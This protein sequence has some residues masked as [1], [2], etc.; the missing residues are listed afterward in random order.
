MEEVT[1]RKG[2]N[3]NAIR[4]IDFVTG[5]LGDAKVFPDKF[6]DLKGS[7]L[8]VTTNPIAVFFS[9]NFTFHDGNA[10]HDGLDV[11]IMD[12]IAKVMNFKLK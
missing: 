12:F 1:L 11:T 4:I 3:N 8:Q 9:N 7:V 5:F 2:V 6:S 10:I